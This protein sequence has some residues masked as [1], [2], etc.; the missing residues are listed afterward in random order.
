MK[1]KFIENQFQNWFSLHN[2]KRKLHCA[3]LQTTWWNINKKK[4]LIIINYNYNNNCHPVKSQS[5][6]AHNYK[7][8]LKTL[9]GLRVYT[10]RI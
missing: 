2:C 10:A 8:Y 9:V 7:L 3:I 5:K 1:A 4:C 6:H